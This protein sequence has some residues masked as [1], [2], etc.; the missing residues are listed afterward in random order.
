M[1][2]IKKILCMV[3]AVCMVASVFVISSACVPREERLIIR[4][5]GEYMDEA[6]WRGFEDW[7]KEKTGGKRV[8]VDYGEFDINETLYKKLVDGSDYDLVCPSDYM[9][10]RLIGEKRV[11]PLW[12]E[13]QEVLK[14][15]IDPNVQEFA[16]AFDPDLEY[17]M[18][19]LW[20]TL[21]IMYNAEAQNR[22]PEANKAQTAQVMSSWT[23][24]WDA[25]F[26]GKIYMKDSPRDTYTVAKLYENSEALLA[27]ADEFGVE[28]DEYKAILEPIFTA[29]TQKSLDDAEA[30]LKAQKASGVLKGGYDVDMAKDELLRDIDGSKG[31]FGMFWSC[32]AGYIMNGD[33]DKGA[34]RNLRYVVPDEGSNVWVDGFVIPK[35][36]VN[37]EA[38]N[39]FIQYLCEKDVAYACM[40]Y[41]GCTSAV[42]EAAEQYREDMEEDEDGFFDNA[43]AGFREMYM[44]MMFPPEDVLARCRIMKDFNDL[45]DALTDMWINVKLS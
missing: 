29:T 3:I 5:W 6:E 23:A 36:A 44:D 41:A 28:S 35:N 39:L 4:N 15:A 26:A 31:Y 40:D 2:T 30:L 17:S 20:G 34:N 27:A 38:A 42:W 45:N 8:K 32:D 25:R 10:E 43:P 37:V 22:T 7:Y 11:Q 21:G 13:T 9:I 12:A 14:K 19:Y 1:K 33:E 16:Q 18:P 24:L